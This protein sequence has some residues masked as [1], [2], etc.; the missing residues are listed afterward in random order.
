MIVLHVPSL[1]SPPVFV[2][3]QQSGLITSKE[4]KW[5]G[6]PSDVVRVQSGK[7]PEVQTKTADVLRR[8]GFGEESN[9]LAGKKTHPRAAPHPCT[10][11][12][13]AWPPEALA[14]TH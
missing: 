3:L 4:C 1:L 13:L 5:M 11:G 7:F 8:H 6:E 12:V 14:C 10:C 9:L 2:E